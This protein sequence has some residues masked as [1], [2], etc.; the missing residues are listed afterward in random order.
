VAQ[1]IRDDIVDFVRYWSRRTEIL[2]GRLLTWLGIPSS[3]YYD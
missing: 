2:V 3:K 1:V